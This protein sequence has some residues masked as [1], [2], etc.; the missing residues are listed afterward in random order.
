ML[1][2][3]P[4]KPVLAVA[5][6]HLAGEMAAKQGRID[7]AVKHLGQAIA[8][9]DELTY[10]E[11]PEWY[12]PI[13]QRLGAVLLEAGRPKQA[14]KAFRDDLVHRPE[15]GWSLHGLARSLRAQKRTRDAARI[16]A[17]FEKAWE[18]ADVE[19]AGK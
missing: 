5:K 8:G 7:E 16:E 9:E 19:L 6:A 1:N 12:L 3:N 15:N 14:E 18:R 2:L 17:R 11:P 13:R 10:A 4:A